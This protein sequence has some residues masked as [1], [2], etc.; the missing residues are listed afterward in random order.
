M[1]ILKLAAS[2]AAIAALAACGSVPLGTV[3]STTHT[4][5][6]RDQ[7]ILFCKDWAKN[8]TD[9]NGRVAASFLLGLTIVGAP[10]A[11]MSAN[12]KMRAL[13][14]QCM[15]ERGYTWIPPE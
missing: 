12:D 5:R 13:Y 15:T 11:I 3:S 6:E 7:D 8:Q 9:T 4:T 2:G 1:N 14:G 10:F